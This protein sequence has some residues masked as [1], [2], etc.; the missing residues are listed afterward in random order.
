TRQSF[1]GFPFMPIDR[2][3]M[4]VSEEEREEILDGLWEEG[5]FKFLWGGFNDLLHNPEAND[6]ASEYIRNKIRETVKDP[7]TAE[8]L[9]PKGSPAG[10]TGPPID[11]DYYETFNRDN[12][13]LVDINESPIEVIT[14]TGLRTTDTEY[15]FDAIVF[16]TGFDAMTGALLRMDIR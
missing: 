13:S 5:G 1:A 15:E 2:S 3:T 7:A 9:C 16:A 6:I 11:T 14:A 10:A 8:L 4:S 12:V